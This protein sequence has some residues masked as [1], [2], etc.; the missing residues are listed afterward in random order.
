[1]ILKI[2][3]TVIRSDQFPLSLLIVTFTLGGGTA[4]TGRQLR[5]HCT[6]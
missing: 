5:L 3:A 6:T 2:E 4:G 1:M